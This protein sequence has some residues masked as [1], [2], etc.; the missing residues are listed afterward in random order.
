MGNKTSSVHVS[1]K[2]CK[3]IHLELEGEPVAAG[4]PKHHATVRV[5]AFSE[6]AKANRKKLK[7]PP[8]V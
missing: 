3:A 7:T 4:Y 2:R 1:I 6:M 5:P 8:T